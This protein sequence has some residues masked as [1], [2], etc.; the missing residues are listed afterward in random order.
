M[1]VS[2]FKMMTR[3]NCALSIAEQKRVFIV[4]ALFT[5][6]VAGGF[7]MAGAWLVM[8]FAGFELLALAAALIYLNGNAENY[9]SV[10]V[11]GD[12]L[13]IERSIRKQVERFE[14]NRHWVRIVAKTFPESKQQLISFSSHGREV[15]FGRY[16]SH[17]QRQ[18]L[19]HELKR[20]TGTSYRN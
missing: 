19:A 1:L 16:M 8:P 11:S 4:I 18:A 5:L 6:T 9:E 13:V 7:S 10:T 14:F 3:P 2:D 20:M 15:E 17:E 12:A